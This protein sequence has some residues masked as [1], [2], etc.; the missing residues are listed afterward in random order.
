MEFKYEA[1]NIKDGIVT[2]RLEADSEAEARAAVVRNGLK[3]LRVSQA[4]RPPPLEE[5]FPS[6]FKVGSKEL[7]GFSRRLSTMIASGG[8]LIR[9][10]EM[11]SQE[12]SNRVMRRTIEAIRHDLDEGSSL[13]EAIAQHPKVFNS[14]Y[15]SVIEV[16]EF[17]GRLG[18][19][20]EQM[21]DILEREAEAKAKAIQTMMYPAAIMGLSVLTLGVLITVALPPLLTTFDKLGAELLVMTRIAIGGATMLQENLVKIIV[22]IVG[23]VVAF[24]VAGKF[25]KVRYCMDATKAKLPIIGS[26]MIASQIARISRTSAMLLEAEVGLA[27]ALQLA[28][29]GIGNA[30]IRKA[31]D[32]AEESLMSG[33]GIAEALARHPILPK[34]FVQLMTIGEASN[35]LARSMAD[36]ADAYQKEFDGRLNTMLGMLEPASTLVVGGIVGFI[37]MSMFVPIYSGISAI[38]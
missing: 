2:G 35:S 7:V 22:A 10:L 1:Y 36:A 9:T 30:L 25:P 38:E 17:T 29:S 12:T 21:S 20:L 28:R 27:P 16:G 6:F 34:M 31:F 24:V 32:D 8:G 19:S 37:A 4:W 23:F 18:P 15:V 11:L 26:L 3:P 14:L 13:S 33:H 5:M